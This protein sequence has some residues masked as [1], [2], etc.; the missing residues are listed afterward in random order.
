MGLESKIARLESEVQYLREDIRELRADFKESERNRRK[1]SA[2]L[3]FRGAILFSAIL[4]LTTFMFII[5]HKG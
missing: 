5:F 4:Y 1:K 2:D 3:L